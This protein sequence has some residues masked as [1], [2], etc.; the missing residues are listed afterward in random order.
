ME[1]DQ[2]ALTGQELDKSHF[3]IYAPVQM[4][5]TNLAFSTGLVCVCV[6]FVCAKLF[7]VRKSIVDVFVCICIALT[8]IDHSNEVCNRF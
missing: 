2:I 5:W 8:D 6:F 4:R 3:H 1:N 7:K